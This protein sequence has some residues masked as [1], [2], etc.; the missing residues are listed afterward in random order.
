MS[1]VWKG[2]LGEKP[3]DLLKHYYADTIQELDF[4]EALHQWDKAQ[5]VVLGGRPC[6]V[7]RDIRQVGSRVGR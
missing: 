5:V 7:N 3:S 6:Q 4:L 2:R 1:F